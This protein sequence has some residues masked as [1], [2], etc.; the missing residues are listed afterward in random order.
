MT[1]SCVA[2]TLATLPTALL[3][4]AF[5]A[6]SITSHV[7]IMSFTDS[8]RG[9][10]LSTSAFMLRSLRPITTF[11][12]NMYS[13]KEHRHLGH[14]NLHSPAMARHFDTYAHMV[15]LGA[16]E[17]V[18]KSDHAPT[19]HRGPITTLLTVST[20]AVVDSSRNSCLFKRASIRCCTSPLHRSLT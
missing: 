12:P 18:K 3:P 13:S 5:S 16:C 14:W 4:A 6:D 15:S 10:H 1:G 8:R 7:R 19:T 20:A 9:M 2:N 11:L 17:Y